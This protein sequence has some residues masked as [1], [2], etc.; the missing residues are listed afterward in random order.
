MRLLRG[1]A[2]SIGG[3]DYRLESGIVASQHLLTSNHDGHRTAFTTSFTLANHHWVAPVRLSAID[4]EDNFVQQRQCRQWMRR[5]NGT[6]GEFGGL[7]LQ[8]A[9]A[10]RYVE[11]LEWRAKVMNA[12]CPGLTAG[13]NRFLTSV[14][15]NCSGKRPLAGTAGETH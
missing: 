12:P 15:V 2:V 14:Q 8:K 5:L 1:E 13:M 11:W 6:A 9:L 10:P 4:P 3:G 7:L